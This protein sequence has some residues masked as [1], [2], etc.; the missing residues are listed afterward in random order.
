MTK[1][2]SLD[3]HIWKLYDHVNIKI[4]MMKNDLPL[5]SFDFANEELEIESAC[6]HP[7][8]TM[9]CRVSRK[10]GYFIINCLLP[11]LMITLCVFFTFMM[12]YSRYQYRFSLLF[13][14]MLTSITFRWAIHGR[15]LPTISYMTFLDVYCVSSIMIVFSAMVWHAFYLV[16]YK[17]DRQLAD[18]CDRYFLSLF[19]PTNFSIFTI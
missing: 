16:L 18:R 4:H 14:T 11:T 6:S 10:P 3:K 5:S 2:A 9:Q 13:T 1:S 15:V 7:A 19:S 8:I 17:R 12:D